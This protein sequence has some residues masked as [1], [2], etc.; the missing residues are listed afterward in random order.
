VAQPASQARRGS[1]SAKRSGDALNSYSDSSEFGDWERGPP[2]RLALV[3]AS[4]PRARR[5]LAVQPTST[6]AH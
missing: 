1:P 5:R 4:T 6:N 3:M 2:A